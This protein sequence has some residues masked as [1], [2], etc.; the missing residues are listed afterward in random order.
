[1]SC[2]QWAHHV[3][4]LHQSTQPAH[5]NRVNADN[6][7]HDDDALSL[8]IHLSS[9]DATVIFFLLFL[10]F[11]V[12]LALAQDKQDCD[13]IERM[14]ELRKMIESIDKEIK[15]R[16]AALGVLEKR[17]NNAQRSLPLNGVARK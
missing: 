16:E 12:M 8:P 17:R 11:P 5:H 15:W 14:E 6:D 4:S 13:R 9:V 10:A 7:D 1:M 2:R 3:M